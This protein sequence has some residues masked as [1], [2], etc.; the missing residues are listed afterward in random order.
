MKK[1]ICIILAAS[2]F[3]TISACRS[4][5]NTSSSEPSSRIESSA[6]S[7]DVSSEDESTESSSLPAGVNPYRRDTLRYTSPKATISVSFPDVFCVQDDDYTPADGI[8]LT[9]KEGRQSLQIE[10]VT[11]EGA[12]I[13]SLKEYL[14]KTYP[15]SEVSVNNDGILICKMD[16]KDKAGNDV[17]AYL[18]AKITSFGY[19]E[20][21]LYFT[22]DEKVTCEPMFSK[23]T[24]Q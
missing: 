20:A 1:I 4:T 7:K 17:R 14:K 24:L 22:E 13:D 16:A 19:N 3:L 15:D 8:Y 23:I 11:S 10:A 6:E 12:D 9:T 2:A 21:V 18:K 5:D